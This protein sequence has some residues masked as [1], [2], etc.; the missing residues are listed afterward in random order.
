MIANECVLLY[1]LHDGLLRRCCCVCLDGCL[2]L[3]RVLLVCSLPSHHDVILPLSPVRL[4]TS[5][6][7]LVRLVS[8]TVGLLAVHLLGSCRERRRQC[9]DRQPVMVVSCELSRVVAVQTVNG[10]CHL[11]DVASRNAM[12]MRT[13]VS[14]EH[15]TVYM[16]RSVKDK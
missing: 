15:Q 13:C 7:R 2:C 4:V 11:H 8:Y 5:R 10:L 14:I 1:E 16:P 3:H 6:K 12:T 9:S